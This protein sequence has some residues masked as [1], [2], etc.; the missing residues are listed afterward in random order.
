MI[1]FIPVELVKKMI[2]IIVENLK[3]LKMVGNYFSYQIINNNFFK[4]LLLGFQ[5]VTRSCVKEAPFLGCDKT[6]KSGIENYEA[7]CY[8]NELLC[9]KSKLNK[10]VCIMIVFLVK[11][12]YL[13]V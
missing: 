2:I 13:A 1:N 10:P 9:N 5:K 8:C 3:L 7:I 4:N 12:V 6:S 11:I